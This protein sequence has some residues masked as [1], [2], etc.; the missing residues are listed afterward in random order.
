MRKEI[1][2]PEINRMKVREKINNQLNKYS[3]YEY[4]DYLS[5]GVNEFV[6]GEKYKTEIPKFNNIKII[7]RNF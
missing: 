1:Y 3:N 7:N 5:N 6:D 2:T 4:I